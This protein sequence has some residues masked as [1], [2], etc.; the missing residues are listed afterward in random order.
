MKNQENINV[1]HNDTDEVRMAAAVEIVERVEKQLE[2]IKK[3]GYK[4]PF[5]FTSA[6]GVSEDEDVI[7]FKGLHCAVSVGSGDVSEDDCLEA[8]LQK[9]ISNCLEMGASESTIKGILGAHIQAKA[10]DCLLTMTDTVNNM[11]HTLEPLALLH[12]ISR[13]TGKADEAREENANG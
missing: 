8:L 12:R 13:K 10:A 7:S 3:S 9:I 5:I 4:L 6:E 11:R 1:N 2:L